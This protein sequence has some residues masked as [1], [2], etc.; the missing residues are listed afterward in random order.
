MG[1]RGADAGWRPLRLPSPISSNPVMMGMF[2]RMVGPVL[3]R[4]RM[5]GSAGGQL[6]FCMGMR[7]LEVMGMLMAAPQVLLPVV[8]NQQAFAMMPAIAEDIIVLL[9]FG[10]SFFFA[11]TIPFAVRMLDDALC[12]QGRGQHAIAGGLEEK[13]V[14]DIHQTVEAETLIDAANFGQ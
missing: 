7:T 8:G 2:M 12:H 10:G 14:I 1:G 4:V 9:T 11:P 13:T 3:M 6:L 5:H